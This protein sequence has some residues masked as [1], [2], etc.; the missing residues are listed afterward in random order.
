MR[1]I[2]SPSPASAR[3]ARSRGQAL[4]ESALVFLA[5]IAM[6]LFIID[7]GR[8]LLISQYVTERARATARMATVNDWSAQDARNFLVYNKTQVSEDSAATPGF[9][10]LQPSMVSYA[11]LGSLHD[12]DLRVQVKVDRVRVP[13]FV[14]FLSGEWTLPP[15]VVEMPAQSLGAIN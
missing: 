9:L 11:L 5:T 7:M 2:A 13:L 14:P 10:G 6:L 15:I 3:R 1:P 8:L 12:G 4:V